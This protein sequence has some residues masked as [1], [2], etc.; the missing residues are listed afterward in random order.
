MSVTNGS[1]V[2]KLCNG[3]KVDRRFLHRYLK[4]NRT[5][6]LT[7]GSVVCKLCNGRKVDRRFLHRYLKTNRTVCL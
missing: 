1:V 7:N 3:R 5:V 6:C 4:T 2:C